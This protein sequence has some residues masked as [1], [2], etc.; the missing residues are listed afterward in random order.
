MATITKKLKYGEFA[1]LDNQ[2]C[3]FVKT[4]RDNEINRILLDK[5]YAFA[6]MRFIIRIAQRN[7]LRRKK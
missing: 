5:T 2:K 4:T 3:F 1:W 6:L 7:W